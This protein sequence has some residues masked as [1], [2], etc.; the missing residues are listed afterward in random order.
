LLE[1][2][3]V[4]LEPFAASLGRRAQKGHLRNYLQGLLSDL[5]RKNVES[6]AYLHADARRDLQ[7]FIEESA[8]SCEPKT[9]RTSRSTCLLERLSSQS[10]RRR[11]VNR[12]YHLGCSIRLCQARTF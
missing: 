6:I 9:K 11:V 3:P 2:L 8:W 4:F 1:R 12:L 5:K 10:Q 7:H